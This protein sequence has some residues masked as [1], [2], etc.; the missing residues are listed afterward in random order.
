MSKENVPI[1]QFW[2]IA[3]WFGPFKYLL[4]ILSILIFFQKGNAYFNANS[5]K[6][7][8]QIGKMIFLLPVLKNKFSIYFINKISRYI[9]GLER[10]SFKTINWNESIC[11]LY[12][13]R[14]TM[15]SLTR[16]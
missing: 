2:A 11:E 4:N 16:Q 5:I 1:V 10:C 8:N 13:N 15:F 9:F 6:M 14:I 3:L 7:T 12:K